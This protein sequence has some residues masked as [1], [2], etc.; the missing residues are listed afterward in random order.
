MTNVNQMVFFRDSKRLSFPRAAGWRW[1]SWW[2][3][4]TWATGAI[5]RIAPAPPRGHKMVGHKDECFRQ[6]DFDDWRAACEWIDGSGK[7]PPDAV[8]I[9]PRLSATLR[10]YANR[11]EVV[12]WKDV[13]Q[14]AR[15]IVEWWRREQDVYGTG[16]PLRSERWHE[17]LASAGVEHFRRMAA[18]YHA[19]YAIVERTDPPLALPVVYENQTYIIYRLK[20]EAKISPLPLGE[21]PGVRAEAQATLRKPS[22]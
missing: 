22:P 7:I 5:D 18:K 21:G 1:Q 20:F 14:S 3:C 9:T 13:P 12:A 17:P 2:P 16:M 8:F 15:K 4:S 6:A 10:W 19:D 11:R